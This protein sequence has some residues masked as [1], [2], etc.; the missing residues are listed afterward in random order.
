MLLSVSKANNIDE[1]LH[2]IG[3]GIVYTTNAS[4]S[5]EYENVHQRMQMFH[6]KRLVIIIFNSCLNLGGLTLIYAENDFV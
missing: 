5:F 3:D 1:Q 4:S 2:C 6:V